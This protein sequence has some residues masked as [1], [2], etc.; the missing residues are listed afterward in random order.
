MQPTNPLTESQWITC[1]IQARSFLE[2]RF[3]HKPTESLGLICDKEW[4]G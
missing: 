4:K 2:D 1:E 3:G